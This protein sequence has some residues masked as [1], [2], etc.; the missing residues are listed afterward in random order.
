M[1]MNENMTYLYVCLSVRLG[2]FYH[3]HES[4]PS[5]EILIMS[6]VGKKQQ[7]EL[8][9]YLNLYTLTVLPQIMS[10][11]FDQIQNK[12]IIMHGSLLLIAN[13]LLYDRLL[14]YM[15]PEFRFVY[16]SRNTFF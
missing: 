14:K 9:K 4:F 16:R 1:K 13:F 7:N 5:R 10:Q 2:N 3:I 8:V 12:E 6:R 11:Y 15:F